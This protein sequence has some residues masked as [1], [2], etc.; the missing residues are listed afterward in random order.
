MS[1]RLK[2]LLLSLLTLVLPW[3]GYKYALEMEEVLRSAERESL[4]GMA[5]TIAASLQGKDDLLYR[6]PTGEQFPKPE[7]F[8]LIPVPLPGE[9]YPDGYIEEWP[10]APG[11]W[12]Y[13]SQGKDRVGIL[14][15]VHERMFYALLD[16]RDDKLVFD[17]PNANP[18]DP[19]SLGDRV[20]IGF[21]DSTGAERQ[22]FFSASSA[23]N[24]RA[25]RI[26][27]RQYG[28]QVAVEEP[29]IEGAWQPTG[30]SQ[31][32]SRQAE[33]YVR[34]TS[35]PPAQGYRLEL[36]IPL[37]LLGSRFGVLIDDRD[38]RGAVPT[39]YGTLR[40]DDLHTQGRL[41]AASPELARY[42][43]QFLQAG[44]RLTVS[45]PEGAQLAMAD[46]LALPTQDNEDRSFLMLLYRRLLDSRG[47]RRQLQAP[48]N[49]YDR[50]HQTVIG[51][52]EVTQTV[53]RWLSLRDHAVT[54]LLNFTLIT[55]AIVVL[56][57]FAFAAHLAVRLS[58]LRKA[59][60][61][62]LTR[63]GLVTTTFPE[64]QAPDELG[65]VAR[66]FSTL[67]HRLNEYTGYL[68]TLAGKL[69]HE[70]RTPLTI[71]R[72]SLDNLETEGGIPASAR[73]YLDRARQGTERLSAMLVAMGAAT[74]VEEAI[75]SAERTR[76]DLVPVIASAVASYRIGFPER[77]FA[78][79]LPEGP[80]EIEGAPDLIVQ[81]L[82][83]LVDNAVDFSPPGATVTVRLRSEAHYAVLEVENPGPSLPADAHARL[84]ES[85]WQSRAR[86]DPAVKDGRPHFG[87]GL[88]I[89]RLIAEFHGGHAKA[90]DLDGAAGARFSVWLKV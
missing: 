55:S 87:L 78:E 16:V 15:G 32:Y 58:R 74:R 70:I 27:S 21:E 76:F 1:L 48:A 86:S 72:S 30:Q 53:D 25:R 11:A 66:G 60:E 54:T 80:L 68:R 3:A 31:N 36:R 24:V 9:P 38:E 73:V 12:K 65:D 28:Q 13:F 56:A 44:L 14:T 79:A 75:Q 69:A 43:E 64:S 52:L 2:L 90:E 62:A 19:E 50:N 23:G 18:L 26:E 84:F 42:L 57:M 63:E 35:A 40:G 37:S 10:D 29:R 8:D 71:V 33:N 46:G 85:L 20:W 67:L 61:S 6:S 88:Y 49:I 81:L 34:Q 7:R 47:E 51:T 17:A 83:K 41:I 4:S 77:G 59:S 45:T 89:V 82:D 5:Q 39:S 22:V